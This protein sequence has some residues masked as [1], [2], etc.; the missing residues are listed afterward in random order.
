MKL[1]P[2]LRQ[3]KRYLVFEILSDKKFSLSDIE[4][5][6][7]QALLSFLGQLGISKAAPL[8]L[9]ER[10]NQN[11]QRFILKTNHSYVNETKSALILIKKIKNT[12]I[13][14]KSLTVSGTIKQANQK[15]NEV[16]K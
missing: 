7:D 14:I 3:K 8:F 11:K 10:F 2:A 16:L 1:L 12:P 4:S 13:I 5:E 6:V 15:L 9:R